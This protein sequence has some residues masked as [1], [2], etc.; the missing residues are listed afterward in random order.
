MKHRLKW[1]FRKARRNASEF[2]KSGKSSC[3]L[4]PGEGIWINIAPFLSDPYS[5]DSCFIV[6]GNFLQTRDYG[7]MV[8]C[9][10]QFIVFYFTCRHLCTYCNFTVEMRF[11]VTYYYC[12]QAERIIGLIPFCSSWKLDCSVSKLS[13]SKHHSVDLSYYC[14][15]L[16]LEYFDFILRG[17]FVQ[18]EGWFYW[19]GFF[20]GGKPLEV[21]IGGVR[22]R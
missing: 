6:A 14:I 13:L 20:W 3:C 22:G 12:F 8:P 2:C 16:K 17:L 10:C 4:L 1:N 15:E 7:K 9:C 19:D 11:F 5:P 21:C 18:S